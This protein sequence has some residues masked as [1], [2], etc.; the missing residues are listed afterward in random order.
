MDHSAG[1]GELTSDYGSYPIE[2]V[3]RNE[4]CGSSR[5]R[6]VDQLVDDVASGLI[7]SGVW[8]IEQPQLWTAG[9]RDC[10]GDATAL[11][12]RELSN[13]N[14]AKSILD[15]KPLRCCLDLVVTDTRCPAPEL[16]V[17]GNGEVVVQHRLVA[18]EGNA[19]A[20][21]SSV[22]AECVPEH[23]SRA[24]IKLMKPGTQA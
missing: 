14:C 13:R 8:L 11:S 9:G 17:L 10:K 15:P 18:D 22:G 16:E 12:G 4:H 23:G 7:K 20:E 19:T 2:L 6:V 1:K 21:R 3:G 5:S 24:G